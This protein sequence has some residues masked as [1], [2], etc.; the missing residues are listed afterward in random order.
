MADQRRATGELSALSFRDYQW[1]AEQMVNHLGRSVDPE[2]IRPLDF[3]AFRNALAARYAPSRLGKTITVC[4]MIFRWSFESELLQQM[5][6]FGP[7]FKAFSKRAARLAKATRG[8]KVFTADAIRVQ[9]GKTDAKFRSMFLLGINGGLGNT[10]LAEL[11]TGRIDTEFAWIDYPRTKTGAP[12]RIPLWPKTVAA[13]RDPSP[14]TSGSAFSADRPT[15]L[16]PVNLRLALRVS[17][18][19]EGSSKPCPHFSPRR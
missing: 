13:L 3:A 5:P 6:R 17:S 10:N 9:L 11:V 1:T 18:N 7:D 8:P 4:R 19:G 15:F 14:P 2:R 12:R 16:Q